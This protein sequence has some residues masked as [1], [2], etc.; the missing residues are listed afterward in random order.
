M[1]KIM[2]QEIRL[3]LAVWGAEGEAIK[4]AEL[5]KRL[6]RK[7]ETAKTYQPLLDQLL[8]QGAIES[9]KNQV[10]LTAQGVAALGEGLA[11]AEFT[12]SGNVGAKTVNALLKW[13]RQNPVVSAVP[14]AAVTSTNGKVPAIDS[15]DQFKQ[16]TMEVYDRLNRDYNMGNLVPI[17]RIRRE[18]GERVN[19]GQF[20]DW[21]FAMQSDDVFELLEESVEDSAPDKIEDS[22]TTKFGK[23][24]CYAK[25]LAS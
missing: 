7:G 8:K 19:R 6:V 20:S 3:L 24:R 16:L 5:T 17:Y 21:L 25:R 13:I 15:Y 22:V 2:N 12:F 18:V 10:S 1:S 14:M 4:K 23:L 11:K 9:N